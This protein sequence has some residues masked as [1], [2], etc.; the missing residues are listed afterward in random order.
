MRIDKHKA[1][2]WVLSGA[3]FCAVVAGAAGCG[4]FGGRTIAAVPGDFETM[5]NAAPPINATAVNVKGDVN[6]VEAAP[7]PSTTANFQ[8]HTTVAEGADSDVVVD[9]TGR[10]IAFAST[11]HGD[12]S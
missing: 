1:V 7:A 11:R 10:F 3:T 4:S 5:E 8:Q 6:G 2:K 9:P 12:H